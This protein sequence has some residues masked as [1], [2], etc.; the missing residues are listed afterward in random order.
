MDATPLDR[1]KFYFDFKWF[2]IFAIVA[3]LIIFEV[4]LCSISFSDRSFPPGASPL[5]RSSVFTPMS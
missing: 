2:L 4:F 5:R 1:R 3:F